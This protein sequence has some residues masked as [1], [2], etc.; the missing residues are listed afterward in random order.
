MKK[1]R[2][3]ILVSTLCISS[4]SIFSPVA[5]F[6][7]ERNELKTAIV[8]NPYLHKIDIIGG[9]VM[10]GWF[11]QSSNYKPGSITPNDSGIFLR[12]CLLPKNKEEKM[13]PE[14]PL[15]NG[16]CVEVYGTPKKIGLIKITISGGMYGNM[17]APASRFSKDYTLDIVNP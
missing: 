6:I 7:P 13:L 4:C 12:N 15:Y 16:N 14:K 1:S 17:F 3:L 11:E 2:I 10:G 5:E 9:N 8:G